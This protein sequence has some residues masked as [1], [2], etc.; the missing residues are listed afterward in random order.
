[1][2]TVGLGTE[3]QKHVDNDMSDRYIGTNVYVIMTF[4]ADTLH[5]NA[6]KYLKPNSST[7]LC[8]YTSQLPSLKSCPRSR[9]IS[10]FER[11]TAKAQYATAPRDSFSVP[12]LLL[13]QNSRAISGSSVVHNMIDR[14]A[15]VVGREPP[16]LVFRGTKMAKLGRIA[17]LLTG[18]GYHRHSKIPSS[19]DLYSTCFHGI[20][21]LLNGLDLGKSRARMTRDAVTL[22]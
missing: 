10:V 12:L 5:F 21:W 18:S 14:I 22:P 1:M 19:K 11:H 7:R 2:C 6:C 8:K 17:S 9:Q 4:R 20:S 3:S 16:V 15:E 13:G